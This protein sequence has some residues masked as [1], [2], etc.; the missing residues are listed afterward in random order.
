MN[1]YIP[2]EEILQKYADVMVNFALWGGKGINKGDVVHV[3]LPESAREFLEPIQVSILRAGGHMILDYKPNDRSGYTRAFF[4]H[5]SDEQLTFHPKKYLLEQ[6]NTVD[7]YLVVLATHDKY[8]LKGV[9]SKKMMEPR[10]A[11]KFF[12]DA[13]DEREANNT[14]SWT[15]CLFGTDAMAEDA[16]LTPEEYWNEIIQ[17]CYLDIEDPV[18]KWKEVDATLSAIQAWLKELDIKTLRVQGDDVDL[19]VKLGE[20]RK[21]LAG[22]GCNIPSFEVFT[23][24]DFRGTNGWI[25][26][27]QPLY[28]YGNRISGIRLEFKDGDVVSATADENEELLKEMVAVPGM[29]K[30]GEFSL[31]DKRLSRISRFMGETLF[32]EN[33]GGEFGNTHIALGKSFQEAYDGDSTV[34]QKEDWLN[35]GFNDSAEHVDIISTTDRT[36]TA[37]LKD[38]TE[39]V[40]YKNGEFQM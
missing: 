16:D 29:E 34:M 27:N 12:Y 5:A 4:E 39:K 2:S 40:I 22:R 17:A 25:T 11:L 8:H 10:K 37:T 31:T 28:R 38:G 30:I 23:S 6:V 26:F 18:G 21:W 14:Q 20:K 36:V 15:I 35:L 9:D 7:H 33:M 1:T 13:R 19:T 3:T 24:P 32:D